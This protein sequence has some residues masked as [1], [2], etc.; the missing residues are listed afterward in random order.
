MSENEVLLTAEGLRNYERELD[1]LKRVRRQEIAERIK[2]AIEYG[3]ISENSEYDSAK[4]EQA[5]IEQRITELERMLRKATIIR[6]DDIPSDEIALGMQVRVMLLDKN[7][8][9]SY[10]IVGSMEAN[11]LKK[12][13]SNESPLGK[14]LLGK[15]AGDVVDVAI[16]AGISKY[17]VL[18]ILRS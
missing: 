7:Q 4:N 12:R 18:E 9:F 13:I 1:E 17:Q 6:E 2:Q 16:P 10:T 5:F 3:D 14:A 8:E 15:R 11:P